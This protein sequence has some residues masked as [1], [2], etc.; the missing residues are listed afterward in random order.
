MQSLMIK[1]SKFWL[2]IPVLAVKA[3]VSL[4]VRRV[5]IQVKPLA[6]PKEMGQTHRFR[7]A[8]SFRS[9]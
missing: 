1:P 6:M 4:V 7:L 3:V 5:R 2:E 9:L 8:G